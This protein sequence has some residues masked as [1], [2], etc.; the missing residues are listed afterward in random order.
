MCVGMCVC[1]SGWSGGQGR[2][3]SMGVENWNQQFSFASV[4]YTWDGKVWKYIG[5]SEKADKKTW[6]EHQIWEVQR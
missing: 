5:K 6:K 2:R 1:V 3:D 4:I